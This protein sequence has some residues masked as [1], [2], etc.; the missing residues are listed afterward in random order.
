MVAET[1]RTFIAIDVKVENSLSS[2]W[3]ELKTLLRN[4]NIKWVDDR[5]LHLTL[6]FLGDTSNVIVNVISSKLQVELKKIPAFNL[7]LQGLGYFGNSSSPRVL[8]VGIS[9]SEQ[10]M[11]LHSV[12]TDCVSVFG[13]DVA[14]EKFS[15]H[16]T[17]G[18]VKHIASTDKLISLI[19]QS[20]GLQFQQAVI[21]KVTFYQSILRPQGPIYKPLSEFKL[22]SL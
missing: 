22:P 4:D 18:R 5:L 7:N 3:T 20:K 19:N 11:Q 9:R 8:W 12:V 10:L 6:F 15:P 14:N 16:L 21:D 17:L 2:K 1:L 13:F